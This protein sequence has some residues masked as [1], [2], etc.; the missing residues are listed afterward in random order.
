MF[1]IVPYK[2]PEFFNN[3]NFI[4]DHCEKNLG[5]QKSISTY[6][7]SPHRVNESTTH[8][9][10]KKFE[11]GKTHYFSIDE[12]SNLLKNRAFV[13]SQ[14][15]TNV[16]DKFSRI[17][18]F[19]SFVSSALTHG[20]VKVISSNVKD[21]YPIVEIGSGIGYTLSESLSS[22]TIR[23]QPSLSECQLLRRTILDPI[24]RMNIEDLYNCLLKNG[25]K[26]PLFFAL[27][28]F[29]T[30]FAKERKTNLSRISQLQSV[31]D[32]VLIMLDTNPYLE[33]IIEQLE[34]L[35][36]EHAVLPYYPL[37]NACNKFSVV[38]VP[39]KFIPF[40]PSIAEFLNM[41]EEE[42]L[43]CMNGPG[44]TK[45]INFKLHQL[46]KEHNLKVI[47]L[48]DF[49]VEQMKSELEQTGY[50]P[51]IYYHAAFTIGDLPKDKGLSAVTEDLLYKSVTD[52][53]SLRQWS[54]N[55]KNLLSGLA[56]KGLK[57][58]GHFNAT[59]LS[60]LREKGQKIFGAEILVI[61]AT[62]TT[63]LS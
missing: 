27:N 24:Y 30:M 53:T 22:K 37:N 50:I 4:M 43:A 60:N 14:E 8:L 23:I 58:P 16:H 11:E 2:I 45:K 47:A 10:L 1:T 7:Q 33:V 25:K 40:T 56:N 31:G 41:M 62:K 6:F 61:E 55:D 9:A 32:K 39:Q 48:E 51:N 15:D 21:E 36:P 34:T 44:L 42:S 19:R 57:I 26:I 13:D 29:D 17:N 63:S 28:V 54:L 3:T 35:Y 12:L 5:F 18:D 38:I 49:F 46:Q 59:F 20:L 52:K